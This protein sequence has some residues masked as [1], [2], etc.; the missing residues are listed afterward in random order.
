[1]STEGI[2]SEVRE[3]LTQ[4]NEKILQADRKLAGGTGEQ[5]VHAAGELVFLKRQRDELEART[6]ALDE[7]PEGG[8]GRT[9]V[10]W[11]KEDWMILMQR[12]E[13][14]IERR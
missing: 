13:S 3:L 7:A 12:L 1:M 14:W 2:K 4:V 8:A 9:V 10:E 11:I 6:R 5:R